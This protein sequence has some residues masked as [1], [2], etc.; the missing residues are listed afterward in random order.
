[1]LETALADAKDR[2]RRLV[3]ELELAENGIRFLLRA[4]SRADRLLRMDD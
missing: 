4:L 3:A 1:M 2:H